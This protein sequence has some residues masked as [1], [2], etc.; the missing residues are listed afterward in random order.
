MFLNV[1]RLTEGLTESSVVAGELFSSDEIYTFLTSKK[2]T[3]NSTI[4]VNDKA[5]SYRFYI[6]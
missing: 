4:N 3:I 2:I 6:L 5:M 1:L